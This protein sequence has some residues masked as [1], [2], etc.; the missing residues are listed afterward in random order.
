[1]VLMWRIVDR[2]VTCDARRVVD[3]DRRFCA[4]FAVEKRRGGD[5]RGGKE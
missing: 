3:R 4:S 5:G 2:V 1:V